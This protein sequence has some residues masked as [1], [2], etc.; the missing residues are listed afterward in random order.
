MRKTHRHCI[1]N[2]RVP[3]LLNRK[4]RY[5]RSH[6][7]NRISGNK[8]SHLVKFSLGYKG[9]CL[10]VFFFPCRIPNPGTWKYATMIRLFLFCWK[11][12]VD[13][14]SWKLKCAVLFC[15]FHK[16]PH[17][18]QRCGKLVHFF[19]KPTF[20]HT[21]EL[22]GVERIVQKGGKW[23]QP[24]LNQWHQVI[25][26]HLNKKH[27][28]RGRFELWTALRSKWNRYVLRFKTPLMKGLRRAAPAVLWN[29]LLAAHRD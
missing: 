11:Q 6:A 3:G 26:F 15:Q 28:C 21:A 20:Q 25:V 4:I 12:L 9:T 17:D 2:W 19:P 18:L 27:P 14:W 22:K 8:T 10:A 16:S 5:P 29:L 7:W 24:L 23:S 1:Q 13:V